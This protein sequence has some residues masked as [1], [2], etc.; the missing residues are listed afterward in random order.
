MVAMFG[1]FLVT[2]L[3]AGW[4]GHAVVAGFGYAAACILAPYLVRRHALLQVVVAPPAIFLA[5]LVVAQVATAQGTGRHGK[6]LSV[7]EGTV[8]TL[9]AL[10][11][12]LVGGTA[13]GAGAAIPRGLRQCVRELRTELMAD[14]AERRPWAPRQR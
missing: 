7:L 10:A 1:L 4:L 13:L 12:W 5:A 3:V 8:L 11:P 9:A 6:V 14:I 2:N